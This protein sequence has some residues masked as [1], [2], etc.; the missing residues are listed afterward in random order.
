[1]TYYISRSGQQYGPY[2]VTELQNMIAQG[3]ISPTDHA[4]G[5]GM[6]SWAPVS[7]V[8][9]SASAPSQAPQPQAAQPQYQQQQQYQPQQAAPQPQYQQPPGYGAPVSPGAPY[10]A[11]AY[12]GG[13]AQPVPGAIP[14]SLHWFVLLLLGCVTGGI[15]MWIWIF[16]QASFV[17]KID[18]L[19]KAMTWLVIWLVTTFAM[20]GVMGYF[21]VDLLRHFPDLLANLQN[22]QMAEEQFRAIVAYLTSSSLLLLVYVVC[23]PLA[24]I[25]MLVGFFSMRNS[26]QRYYNSAEPIGLRLSGVMTFFFNILYFQ[27]HFRRIARWKQTGQLI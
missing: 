1:M 12:A 15:L 20:F 2:S 6:A 19:S 17:K 27:Y 24:W 3:Q 11:P 26:I 7:E 21:F 9:A 18:P 14:P 8:L 22:P 5:E 10:G 16:I 4:W 13:Y 23:A 25:F